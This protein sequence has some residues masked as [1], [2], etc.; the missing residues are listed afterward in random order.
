MTGALPL[1]WID[2]R[3]R[4]DP[5]DLTFGSVMC[6]FT[7]ELLRSVAAALEAAAIRRQ[8][9]NRALADQT[10]YPHRTVQ[11]AYL[12]RE[13]GSLAETRPGSVG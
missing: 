13:N 8:R 1:T 7:Q 10:G 2:G 12:A 4:T 9:P 11:R 3:A 5:E 6:G